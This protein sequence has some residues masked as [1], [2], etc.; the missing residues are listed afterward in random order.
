MEVA[1]SFAARHFRTEP[2]P[3]G[4]GVKSLECRVK[5]RNGYTHIARVRRRAVHHL[6]AHVTRPS[7][8][9]S[10]YSILQTCE[11]GTVDKNR[12]LPRC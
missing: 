2:T 7:H 3:L 6:R 12:V 1:T 4:R 5:W 10:H 8:D 9:L 11:L